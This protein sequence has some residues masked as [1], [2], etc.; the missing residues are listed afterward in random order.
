MFATSTYGC[1]C[2][3]G[4]RSLQTSFPAV[5]PASTGNYQLPLQITPFESAHYDPNPQYSVIPYSPATI[6]VMTPAYLPVGVPARAAAVDGRAGTAALAAA[7]A[8]S[9][10]T[11][12]LATV[13]LPPPASD[14][15]TSTLALG[16]GGDG[17]GAPEGFYNNGCT[18]CK[19]V[20]TPLTPSGFFAWNPLLTQFNRPANEALKPLCGGYRVPS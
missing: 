17:G 9:E 4:G 18:C 13:Q 1:P 2:A 16:G 7:A 15:L 20:Y 14:P 12:S 8:Q 10:R 3:K 6:G 19:N 5:V 11:S